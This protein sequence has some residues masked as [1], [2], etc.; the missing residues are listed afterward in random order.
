MISLIV[1]CYNEEALI[2]ESGARITSVMEA[3]AI[4]FEIIFINDGSTDQ[5]FSIIQRMSKN[6]QRVKCISFS[7]NFGHQ[8]AVSA[9]IHHASGE[10]AVILDADLQDPPE[11]IPEI[12]D[13]WRNSGCNVVYGVRKKRQQETRF[14]KASASLYYRLLNSLSEVKLANDSGDFRLIDRTVIHEFRRFSERHKYIRGLISWMGFKQVPFYYERTGRMAGETKYTLGKMI[15]LARYGMVYFSKKPLQLAVNLGFICFIIGI[16]LIIYVFASRYFF[17]NNLVRGWSSILIA[18]IFF[19]GVQLLSIGLL[20]EY[21]GSIFD[22]VKGR[23]EYIAAQMINFG[24]VT[25]AV[26]ENLKEH[27]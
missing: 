15:R 13:L 4:P 22:E 27:S 16:L 8:P 17:P 14:K 11:L 21:I 24:N 5:T 18:I 2:A 10:A 23:P 12:I 25:K 1:P 9:G 3:A 26:S 20:G 6:D 7:R 19:G